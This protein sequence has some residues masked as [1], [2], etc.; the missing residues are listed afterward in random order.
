MYDLE[1]PFNGNTRLKK[2]FDP[3][4]AAVTVNMLPSLSNFKTSSVMSAL[5]TQP[6]C[7][8][9]CEKVRLK[10]FFLLI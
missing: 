4:I 2:F 8:L 6:S 7:E 1:K 9:Q 5:T 3:Y 10:I